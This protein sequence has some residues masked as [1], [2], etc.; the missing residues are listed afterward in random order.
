M[1]SFSTCVYTSKHDV[2]SIYYMGIPTGSNEI[3]VR[4]KVLLTLFKACNLFV[5]C[6]WII[7]APKK[8]DIDPM[9]KYYKQEI[10]DLRDPASGKVREVYKVQ[11]EHPYS[12]EDFLDHLCLHSPLGPGV[13][14]AALSHLARCLAE[15]LAESGSV[16]LPRVG[17]FRVGIRPRK[18]RAK[19]LV[20]PAETT[21]DD[22]EL[23]ARS[24]ELSHITFRPCR[25]LFNDVYSR[26]AKEGKL[27]MTEY[28]GHV[29]LYQPKEQ[30][31]RKRFAMA[32]DFLK[33]HPFL[34]IADYA[35]LT[36]LSYSTAQR[37]L[38]LA[39]QLTHSGLVAT[40]LGSH[41]VYILRTAQPSPQGS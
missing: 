2:I 29:P 36:G 26:L 31:R 28:G 5:C 1:K 37:E 6:P 33:N 30:S 10:K 13:M 8:G 15:C 18:G 27:L 14:Q 23:N 16:T 25:T 3:S 35:T 9:P 11:I 20:D 21:D 24:L 34:R 22:H 39:A 7:F 17:T 19:G 4:L 40:G 38:R 12:A 32:C 41:R